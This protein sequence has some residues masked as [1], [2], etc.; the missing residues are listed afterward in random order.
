[1]KI[2]LS[3]KNRK[4]C[5]LFTFVD[6]NIVY[7][8]KDQNNFYNIERKDKFIINIYLWLGLIPST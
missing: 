5:I 3:N 4:K 2:Y 1:M 6:K 8:N 7:I